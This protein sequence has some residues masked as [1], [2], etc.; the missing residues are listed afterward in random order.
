MRLSNVLVGG[1]KGFIGSHFMK[2]QSVIKPSWIGIDMKDNMDIWD[3]KV[4]RGDCHA[5]VLFAARLD[6][7]PQMYRHN[8]RIY[9]WLSLLSQMA[10]N[11]HVIYTS[12]AAV[13]P[14]TT[15]EPRWYEEEAGDPPTIYG[16]SK[17]LGERIL[18]DTMK[19]WTIL[20]LGN[21]YGDGDGNGVIDRFKNGQNT[22]YGDGNQV[23]D[24]I[25]VEKV[26]DVI[27]SILND[28][29]KHN[30]QIYNI[31]SGE[32]KTVNQ[33]W[34]EFGK[35]EPRYVKARDFDVQHSVLDNSK[36]VKAGLL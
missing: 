35:G 12:S 19:N 26:C 36:A 3:V 15:G 20:R 8:L 30:N 24:Y 2:R 1:S 23:R 9:Y 13:Y 18:Q 11:V 16:K 29:K 32:G 14:A 6:H 33:V 4:D 5:V 17:L 10:P 22:I 7:T 31:S 27:V 34:E 28:H 25:H 21:V